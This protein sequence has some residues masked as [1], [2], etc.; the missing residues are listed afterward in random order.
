MANKSNCD[1]NFIISRW[2][3]DPYK[4]YIM[5]RMK[6]GPVEFHKCLRTE[7]KPCKNSA[8]RT[9]GVYYSTLKME[10]MFFCNFC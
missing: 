4:G 5:D 7:D 6:C 2:N 10:A 9:Q 3:W 1:L 8:W